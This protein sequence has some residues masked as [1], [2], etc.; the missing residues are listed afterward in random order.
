MENN[1]KTVV[2]PAQQ[3]LDELQNSYIANVKQQV[4]DFLI[5]K[6]FWW[7]T[8]GEEKFLLDVENKLLWEG[9]PQIAFQ[10]VDSDDAPKSKRTLD[11]DSWMI[12]T[13]TDFFR[14]S[15]T[16]TNPM[17]TNGQNRIHN[18]CAWIVR[19]GNDYFGIDSD[20]G[21]SSSRKS[22]GYLIYVNEDI[23]QDLAK[24]IE[25]L[26]EN[27]L[28]ISSTDESSV[29]LLQR[30]KCLSFTELYKNIDYNCCRLPKLEQSQFIDPNKGLWEFDGLDESILNEQKVRVRDPLKDVRNANIG[31][32][33]GTSSTVVAYEDIN[34]RAKLLRIG[35]DDYYEQVLPEHYENPTVL[36]FLDFQSM[37][38]NW[39]QIAQQPLVNWDDV[40]CSHEALHNFR[41]NG[42]NPKVVASILSKL[43]QWALREN[44]DDLI[45]LTDQIHD[46]EHQLAHLSLRNPVKGA[47]LKVSLQDDFDPI[48]LYAWFLGL[49]INWRGRGLFLK[50]YMTFPV[51]YPKD[52]KEKILASFRRGLLRSL[53]EALTKQTNVMEK[54]IVEE[55]A[56]EPAAYV[57]ASMKAYD[58]EPTDEGLAYAVFDFGGGTTD[59]DFGYYRWA[60]DEENEQN[61]IEE[62]FE[63]FEAA[64]DKFL[65]GENL[66]EN[67]AY[68]VFKHNL[69]IC[70]DKKIAFTRPLDAEDFTGSEMLVDKTQ[71]AHTNTLMVM[72]RLRPFWEESQRNDKGLESLDLLS[73][74]GE[75]VFC[76]LK[77]PFDDLSDYL[78]IRIA[79]GVES[80]LIAMRK[81]FK[82]VMPKEVHVL[83]A[84]NSS[85]S[86]RVSKTFIRETQKS[87]EEAIADF[88]DVLSP[89]VG[90]TSVEDVVEHHNPLL[91]MI[92]GD[93]APNVIIHAPLDADMN[94]ESKPTA[95]TGVAL[96]ILRL[97]P[98]TE[99]EVINHV[100]GMSDGEAPF[101]Y[102]V[103]RAR[104]GKFQVR[105]NR[106]DSYDKWSEIGV[107]PKEGVFNFYYT[108]SNLAFGDEMVVGH[109]ELY[110]G[111]IVFP[112]SCAGQKIYA[113]PKTPTSVN[114]GCGDVNEPKDFNTLQEVELGLEAGRL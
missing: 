90:G 20:K 96:G 35:V 13:I 46:Y 43:K 19:S 41:N 70:R 44:S 8:K 84:G 104:R 56:S 17:R 95:K 36:E 64:G 61:A 106:S 98:G 47:E 78:D 1:V 88:A 87:K 49:N 103:G 85:R 100:S 62:V 50:Y 29:D 23:A 83:L 105:L 24:F 57:A 110:K 10:W 25:F 75:A 48:E 12:P 71:V 73:R 45:R 63:H 81:A 39:T 112:I 113:S 91:N 65:G 97:C 38:N 18:Q 27:E 69:D 22:G 92:F 9:D 7:V 53:P 55:R 101:A 51:A 16:A 102:Y 30:F 94:D 5:T 4:L 111:S 58:I 54:F 66:L 26:L 52:V 77:I 15:R 79:Q 21:R 34:G 93:S 2:S 33:F 60:T 82:E 3:V 76:E 80:F 107:V 99:V 28:Q 31:I 6:P 59:F 74:D 72:S 37:L 89:F 114:I 67:M 42:S 14:F 108:Q 68:L 86:K 40:R 109:T 11:I 32:D